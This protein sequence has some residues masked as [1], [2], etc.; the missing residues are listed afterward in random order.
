MIRYHIRGRSSNEGNV[1]RITNYKLRITNN[2]L[3]ITNYELR[4]T[5]DVGLIA[6]A[7]QRILL[8]P[9][10][11]WPPKG[12]GRVTATSYGRDAAWTAAEKWDRLFYLSA[13]YDQCC[14]VP[15]QSA[16]L[17]AIYYGMISTGD[18]GYFYPLREHS[19]RGSGRCSRTGATHRRAE[20]HFPPDGRGMRC[21]Q[22]R[23]PQSGGLSFLVYLRGAHALP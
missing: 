10:G 21:A 7:R 19:P 4:I 17:T 11:R 3:Q 18:H 1:K 20:A 9:G 23:P 2:E 5:N 6:S 22:K 14:A 8:P 12:V 16:S 13:S 15:L